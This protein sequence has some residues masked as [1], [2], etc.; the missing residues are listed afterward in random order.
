[1]TRAP[2]WGSSPCLGGSRDGDEARDPAQAV[3]LALCGAFGYALTG[4]LDQQ[5]K[6]RKATVDNV[7]AMAALVN[8]M[9]KDGATA[10]SQARTVQ[11]LAM[12]GRDAIG[13]LLIMTAG[14]GPFVAEV[15]LKGLGFV[16]LQYREEVCKAVTDTLAA[17]GLI[18]E[19]NVQPIQAF[20]KSL[21]C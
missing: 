16:A 18:A 17:P 20:R 14:Q 12:Y 2:W 3:G 9:Y 21:S 4:R 15:P 7:G 5:L 1:L 13:P 11:H 10:A 19:A 8:D 6:E